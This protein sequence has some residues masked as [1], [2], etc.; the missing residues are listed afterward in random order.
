MFTAEEGVS[1]SWYTTLGLTDGDGNLLPAGSV[2]QLINAGPNQAIE[3]PDAA[4]PDLVGG[5]DY[6]IDQ[7]AIGDGF[8]GQD[9]F[10]LGGLGPYANLQVGDSA[11]IR[12]FTLKDVSQSEPGFYGDS[13]LYSGFYDTSGYVVPPPNEIIWEH[14]VIDQPFPWT[15]GGVIEEG[16]K[17]HWLSSEGLRDSSGQLLPA[18]S[19]VQLIHAGE[20]GVADGLDESATDL[21]GGDDRV[22]DQ[23][24]IGDGAGGYDGVFAGGPGP[25]DLS[26]DDAVFI[27]AFSLNDLG[28]RADGY[29]QNSPVFDGLHETN[30]TPPP[31]PNQVAWDNGVIDAPLPWNGRV[32][33]NE[34]I[35]IHWVSLEGLRDPSGALLATG[36]VVQLIDAGDNGVPD[37]LD[38]NASNLAGGDDV[39]LDQIAVG[40]G[41]GGYPGLFSGG[42]GPYDVTADDAVF[43]RAFTLK[44]LGLRTD[45]Y[46]ED[47]PLFDSLYDTNVIPEPSPNQLVWDNDV[48][49]QPLPWNDGVVENDG[50]KINWMSISG[51]RDASGAL[52]PAGSIVQLIHAG[53]NGV[54]DGFDE[55][56][57]DLAAGD[58]VVLDQVMIGFGADGRDGV[59]SAG[60]GPYDVTAS[61]NIFIRAFT[62]NDLASRQDGY[63][64]DSPFLVG[65]QETRG[66]AS[67]PPNQVSW[68]FAVIDQPLPWNGRVVEEQGIQIHW[69][70]AG[71]LRDASGELLP[72]GSVVQLID[73]GANGVADGLDEAAQDL[74]GGDDVVL[75]QIVVG[76]GADGNPGVFS[77]GLGPYDIN[78]GDTVFM[79]A[80]TVNDLAARTDGYYQ[81][82]PLYT[83]LHDTQGTPPPVPNQLAWEGG[84]IDEALPWNQP[85]EEPSLTLTNPAEG[86]NWLPRTFQEIRWESAYTDPNAR[87]RIELWNGDDLVTVPSG[88][89][90]TNNDGTFRWRVPS[91]LPEADGYRIVVMLEDDP[92]VFGES[93]LFTIGA[94]RAYR[95][96]AVT[97]PTEGDSWGLKSF[98]Q[99]QWESTNTDS[100]ERI[101]IE[102]WK[103]EELVAVPT[104]DKGTSNNG[105]YRWRV[106]SSLLG[107]D[108]YRVVVMLQDDPLV[109][110][111]S[112][113]F[114][115]GEPEP[116][117]LAHFAS[118]PKSSSRVR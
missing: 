95:S 68:D 46:Y 51:L 52:L 48:V 36:S 80:F 69:L 21:A 16:L 113:L 99:I 111:E 106:P 84:V 35:K 62:L 25:Y 109:R 44:D 1:L 108:G 102:L 57:A 15:D 41:F 72:A 22:L 77:G 13:E 74:A 71:G 40:D 20:N 18:G 60:P 38:T 114:S 93:G 7:I 8:S 115:I 58:D 64:L 54:V 61:D 81:D 39:V 47:S 110:S 43:I 104:G 32:V 94:T 82:S 105:E 103:G 19:V 97:T 90:G 37:A 100:R 78:V 116:S 86:D 55:G 14:G 27:R 79:R 6:L 112:G 34:G 53:E 91:S 49:D 98:Q 3:R 65:L 28:A 42:L 33:E 70:S 29:Y 12:A 107:A 30:G 4:S 88:R 23:I 87:V 56:A 2:V 117:S 101:R 67:I 26:V 85:V 66:D 73:A 5:D 83:D 89:K 63:Y 118:L 9:G 92:S 75:D 17:I 11:Y 24:Q 76:E 50:L 96:L 59:F 45:G 10:F 31:V